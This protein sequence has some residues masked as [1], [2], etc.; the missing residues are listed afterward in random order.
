MIFICFTFYLQLLQQ[1]ADSKKRMITLSSQF[2]QSLDSLMKTLT[3]CQPFFIRCIKPN[4]FKKPM[5][6]LVHFLHPWTKFSLPDPLSIFVSAFWQGTVY[7]ST[8]LL[9][10]DGDYPHQEGRISH[11]SHFWWV[12]GALPCAAQIQCLWPQNCERCFCVV[13]DIN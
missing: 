10:N 2:R 3:S 1:T 13:F 5:V 8:S 6:S 12:S 11:S 9:W 7:P 4:D